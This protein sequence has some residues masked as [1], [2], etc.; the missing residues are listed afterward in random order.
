[1]EL[2]MEKSAAVPPEC[3]QRSGTPAKGQKLRPIEDF[4]SFPFEPLKHLAPACE[5]TE[6]M[7]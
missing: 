3:I 7:R 4:C 2:Q 1:M 5:F 6:R